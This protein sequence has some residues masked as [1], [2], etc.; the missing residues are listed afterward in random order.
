MTLLLIAGLA[1]CDKQSPP[2]EQAKVQTT[3]GEAPDGA[4]K[5]GFDYKIDRSKAGTAA[6]DLA[7]QD[8]DG[9]DTTLRAFAG[10]PALVN[11]WATWCAPC[12][13]E[14]PMLDGIAA[15]YGPKGLAVLTISQDL[16][17][18]PIKGFFDKHALPHLKGWHDPENRL[19]FHYA[20]GVLPTSVL[21]D[22]QG[23]EMVRV[24]GAMDWSDAEGRK[25]IEAA[26]ATR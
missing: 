16:Q 23:K 6:P 10:R 19:G 2:T 9:R 25:L 1:A 18:A 15:E 17:A 12:V 3:T 14:M 24:V 11:L 13:A 7:F 4:T 5:G 22:A 26:M 21:Y 8:A 20:T